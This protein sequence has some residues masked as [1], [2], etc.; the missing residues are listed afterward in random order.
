MGA[1]MKKLLTYTIIFTLINSNFSY[2]A[3]GYDKFAL[4]E[5][6]KENSLTKTKKYINSDYKINLKDEY[7]NTALTYSIYNDNFEITRL[8]L[9]NGADPKIKDYSGKEIYC[10][11]KNSEDYKIRK[12]FEDYSDK[13]CQKV[14]AGKKVR[15]KNIAA[16]SSSGSFWNWK[17]I[18]SGVLGL[19]GIVAIAAAGGRGGGDSSSSSG[20]TI[21]SPVDR[22][23]G[24]VG[25]VDSTVLSDILN[26]SQYSKQWNG[27]SGGQPVTFS[28]FDH[29]NEIRLAYSLARGYTGKYNAA[30]SATPYYLSNSS[31]NV[32]IADGTKIKVAVLDSGVLVNHEDFQNGDGTSNITSNLNGKNM[33]YSYCQANGSD[34]LCALGGYAD[35]PNP[36]TTNNDS[37]AW[38][39]T[40]VAGIIGASYS[41]GAGITGV[42]PDS[43]I[44]PFRLTFN[45]GNFVAY[46]YIGRAFEAAATAGATVVNNSY[47]IPTKI[48]D[49]NGNYLGENVNASDVKSQADLVRIFSDINSSNTSNYI[50]QMVNAVNNNDVIFVWSAGNDGGTQSSVGNAIP[51]FYSD[52]FKD[53]NYY[54]NFINVVAY[55][56]ENNTIASYSN[57]CG[58]TKEYC[59]TAPGTDI[60]STTSGTNLSTIDEYGINSGTSFAAPM[61]SGAVAV[62]KGA[63]PYLTGSEI[64]RLIFI[65][66]RDLGASGVD[67]VYGWGMLDLERATRPV[68]ATIVPIDNRI[69]TNGFGLADSKI[70]LN[71]KLAN[72]LKSKNL[73]F[74][75]LDSF[76]RTFNMKLNDFIESERDRVNTIDVLKRFGESGISSTNLSND[77]TF[78]LYSASNPVTGQYN[79]VEFSYSADSINGNSY[80]FN[81]YYGNNPYNAFVG[82]KVDFYNNYSLSNSYGYNAMNPYF[83]SDSDINFGFNNILKLGEKTA[84]NFG[85]LYQNYTIDYDKYYE[86]RKS[87]EDLGSAFS[88]LTGLS[89]GVTNYL[90]TKL[91]VGFI[92]EY[93]TLFGSKLN[94]AFG[95]GQ[96]NLTYIAS[97]QNDLNLFENKLTLFGKASFGYT[98]I[99]QATNSLIKDMTGLYSNSF[100]FGI[101][102]N[103]DSKFDGQ[104]S[105][106]SLLFMQPVKIN[107]GNIKMSLPIARDNDG[108]LYYAN[109]RIGL[110]DESEINLQLAYN[111]SIKNDSSFNIGFMYRDY[112]EDEYILL[113]KYKKAFNF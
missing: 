22:N 81:M 29:F 42:A 32:G 94:G 68:G 91:E 40:F 38:H 56:T 111:R 82:D 96:N 44:I 87:T 36:T 5:A 103:F 65:T 39:G 43:E 24:M 37:T 105:N 33:V 73:D 89:Y 14:A 113:L 47:G 54:K 30:L 74:V 64:T 63:F 77:G 21:F 101:N 83:K 59:I 57:Q 79:E 50:N 99:N 27:T 100:T 66:A 84:L 2:S 19:G 11:A 106:I 102:Y 98:N 16:N 110:K 60:I 76:N 34:P 49:S 71:S 6:V 9:R 108:N 104:R 70:K 92:N 72:S 109:H 61:V 52:T 20:G 85:I 67:E 107:S 112:I 86:N 4:I 58:V 35:N 13:D 75:I 48:W 41:N 45:N 1:N 26:N 15:T 53:G 17:T 25:Q 80:G 12:L 55:D 8:L 51:L 88:F 78:N 93:D 46:E 28:N 31:G 18:G 23:Y 97:V 69:G 3:N 10:A 62:L 7:N 95:I 90:T